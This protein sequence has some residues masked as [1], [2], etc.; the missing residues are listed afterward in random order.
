MQWHDIADFNGMYKINKS[1]DIY[2]TSKNITLKPY[3][4]FGYLCVKLYGK[5]GA[6]QTSVHI[7]VAK[8]FVDN[9]CNLPIV[10]HK[11]GNKLNNHFRNLEW[12]T[13]Q[14]NSEHALAKN[15]RFTSP[16]GVS[17]PIWN[18]RKFCASYG[19]NNGAM[20]LLRRG[21]ISQH[22]GWTFDP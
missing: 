17:I 20:H 19:L 10:N 3:I 1:G 15:Y 11:D 2:S 16:E 22:K 7:L 21:V 8:A 18:L 12:C 6:T 9:P 14:Y 4:S 5:V 13:A